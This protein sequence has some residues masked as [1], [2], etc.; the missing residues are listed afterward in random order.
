MTKTPPS[1]PYSTLP[2]SLNM[3]TV[4]RHPV[5]ILGLH[6]VFPVHKYVLE[7]SQFYIFLIVQRYHSLL[8]PE[9]GILRLVVGTC[10]HL[11]HTK[12]YNM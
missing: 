3:Y 2:V 10:N 6:F 11:K 8:I 7:V 1:L 5:N 4:L 9:H 12:F